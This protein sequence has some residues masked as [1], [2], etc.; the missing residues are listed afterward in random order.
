MKYIA[1]PKLFNNMGMKEFDD[2]REAIHRRGP[3]ATE[4]AGAARGHPNR[5]PLTAFGSARERSEASA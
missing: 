4:R 3:N 5:R 1:K 2:A